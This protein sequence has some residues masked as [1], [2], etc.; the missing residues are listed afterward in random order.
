KN[1]GFYAALQLCLKNQHHKGFASGL[2]YLLWQ[3][4]PAA[5]ILTTASRS[6]RPLIFVT[7]DDA[8]TSRLHGLI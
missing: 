7:S 6:Q 2:L 3:N 8:D 5:I 4:V 1:R